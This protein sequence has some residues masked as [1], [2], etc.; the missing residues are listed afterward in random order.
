MA[1]FPVNTYMRDFEANVEDLVTGIWAA[2]ISA[3]AGGIIPEVRVKPSDLKVAG[4]K[5]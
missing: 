4:I 3:G 2:S 5:K 1:D